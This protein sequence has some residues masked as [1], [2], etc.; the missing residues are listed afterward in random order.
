MVTAV[1][2]IGSAAPPLD[3]TRW[4]NGDGHSLTELR[5]Q[6][7][8]LHAFQMLC[9]GCVLHGT[10]LAQRV[11]AQ[12][13]AEG[14]TVIGLHSVFEHHD[15]MGPAS[16]STYLH[17]FGITMAVGVDRHGPGEAMPATMKAYGMRG[18]PTLV[19]IDRAGLIRHHF[20]G[21]VDELLLGARIGHLLADVA[22]D[23][24]PQ[25]SEAR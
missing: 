15:A 11:H 3:V 23:N 17:E 1:S 19:L 10:P 5:G 16:L 25:P 4:F 22:S 14:L 6:V 12:F 18:T 21:H 7:V 24:P 13:G 9:P 2:A 8:V 20:F